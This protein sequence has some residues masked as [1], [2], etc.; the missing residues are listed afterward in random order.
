MFTMVLETA[1]LN[2]TELC[3]YCQERGLYPEQVERWR[4][5]SKEGLLN[6]ARPVVAQWI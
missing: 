6:K 2:V 5:A 1:G 4:Q 3:A